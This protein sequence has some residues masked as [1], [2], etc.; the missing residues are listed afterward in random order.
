MRDEDRKMA[1]ARGTRREKGTLQMILKKRQKAALDSKPLAEACE[2][3][4]SSMLKV[5]SCAFLLAVAWAWTLPAVEFTVG[6]M[7]VSPFA[8]TEISPNMTINKA[9]V[10]YVDLKFAFEGAPTDWQSIIAKIGLKKFVRHTMLSNR[11]AHIILG[12][13][14]K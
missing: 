12:D 9:D 5:R 11:E 13:T 14:Q 4:T 10:S 6:Q 1:L 8:D 7:P 2:S 3:A